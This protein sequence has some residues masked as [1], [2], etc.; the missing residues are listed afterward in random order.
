MKIFQS[1]S[2]ERKVKKFSEAQKLQLDKEVRLILEDPF[3]G[4]EKKGDLRGVYVHKFKLK[5]IQ[6]LLAYRIVGENLELII[7]GPHQNYYRDLKKDI[8][9]T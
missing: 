2:F 4:F 6:Y 7:I 8:K 5:S 1:R 9:R 3:I